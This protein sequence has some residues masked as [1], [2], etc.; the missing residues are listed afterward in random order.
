MH[1]WKHLTPTKWQCKGLQRG[2]TA[3][4]DFL[5]IQILPHPKPAAISSNLPLFKCAVTPRQQPHLAASLT[6]ESYGFI[7]LEM[8]FPIF[9]AFPAKSLTFQ[10]KC[11][12]ISSS[13]NL[14]KKK[15]KKRDPTPC[16]WLI[17]TAYI[18]YCTC[19]IYHI[20]FYFWAQLSFVLGPPMNEG[21]LRQTAWPLLQFSQQGGQ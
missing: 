20:Y 1:L 21:T 3:Q 15:K 7:V 19:H 5:E 13:Q 16:I 2:P 9:L 17:G 18:V 14:T 6:K 12:R 11:H 4:T 10:A 8:R